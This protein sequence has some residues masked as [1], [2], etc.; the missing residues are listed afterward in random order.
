MRKNNYFHGV[1]LV[2]NLVPY[3]LYLSVTTFSELP[4]ALVHN[5]KLLWFATHTAQRLHVATLR[6]L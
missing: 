6:M 5:L 3:E 4:T 2:E 1:E